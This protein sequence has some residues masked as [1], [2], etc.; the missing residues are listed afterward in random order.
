MF[1]W[2]METTYLAGKTAMYF[3]NAIDNMGNIETV[4]QCIICCKFLKADFVDLYVG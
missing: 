4:Q 2:P 3:L 1:D